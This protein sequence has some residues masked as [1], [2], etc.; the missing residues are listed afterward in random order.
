MNILIVDDDK[1]IVDAI[2]TTVNWS[3]LGIEEIYRAYNVDMA[4]RV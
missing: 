2:E 4:E 3:D 1:I